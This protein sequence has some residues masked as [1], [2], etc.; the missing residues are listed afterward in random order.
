MQDKSQKILN[1][2][3]SEILYI[4]FNQDS[5]CIS[6]GTESGFK[7]VKTNPFLDL[8]YRDMKGGIGIVEML[9]N[10]NILGLAGGG[11][12]PKY[13]LNEFVLWDEEKGDEI[14]RI[15]LNKKILNLK[16]KENKIYIVTSEKIYLFDFNLNLIDA[17]ESK[18]SLGLISLCYK[19][20]IIAYPDKKIEGYI[21]IKNYDKKL[22]YF[23]FA[24]TTPLSCLHLNQEGDLI[25]T[26][27]LKGTLV[28]IYSILN[29]NLIQEVRRGTEGSFIN[30]I[31]FDPSQKYFAVTSD[32]KTIHLFFLSNNNTNGLNNSDF[33][34]SNVKSKIILEEEEKKNE[35]I[36]NKKSV[37]NGFNKFIKYF[38]AEYSFTR[39]KINFN[40]SICAFGPDNTIII[41]SYDGKYYQVGFDPVNNSESFKLQEEKF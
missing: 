34:N 33:N 18:N 20:D 15:K 31:S 36:D 22:N 2:N 30:Y 13:P 1:D 11:K 32:R 40:K 38:G 41:I 8:Y 9:Y 29:G 28:R 39:F 37:F 23:F 25:A 10:T 5:S 4:S 27:S 12:N 3:P 7:I 17:L 16:L 26:S 24:H 35:I 14:G 19:E 21:R 6:I